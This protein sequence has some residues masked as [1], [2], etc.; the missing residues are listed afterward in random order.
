MDTG[1]LGQKSD[2]YLIKPLIKFDTVLKK[3]RVTLFCLFLTGFLPV[4]LEAMHIIGGEISYKYLGNGSGNNKRFQFTLR[5]FRD[6]N[7]GGAPF[8]NPAEIAIYRGSYNNNVFYTNFQVNL[9][10]KNLINPVIPDCALPGN[11][12]ECVEV[13]TY[14]FTRDLPLSATESYFIVYQRC[15]RNTSIYNLINPGDIGATYMVEV[16]P[17]AQSLGNSSPV[18]NEFPPVYICKDFPISFNHSATDADGDLLVYSLCAPFAGGG[19]DLAPPDNIGCNGATPTPPCAPPFLNVPFV[20]PDYSPTAP[21]GGNPVVTINTNTGMITGVPN[22]I[23]QFVVGVCV[24]EF[25]GATLMSTVKRDFQFNVIDCDPLVFAQIQ[26]DSVFGVKKYIVTSCGQRTVHL[27]NESTIKQYINSYE[28]SFDIQGTTLV[29]S[30]ENPTI[31]FPDTGVYYGVLILNKGEPCSDTAEIRVNIFPEI[32]ADYSY[33]YD[34]CVAGPVIFTDLSYSEAGMVDSWNWDFGVAGGGST[35]PSPEYLYPYP[36]NHI[37]QLTV[38]DKNQCADTKM[39]TIQWYPA[40]PY[41]IVQPDKFLG[42]TPAEITFTNLSSPID[43]TYFIVWDFGDGTRDT[44][45]ISPTHTYTTEGFYD[46]SVKI[47][48]PIGC[49]VQDSFINWI[50][51]STSPIANF[52]C[53]PD[54]GLTVFNKTVQFI[55]LSQHAYRWYWNFDGQETSNEQNP[56]YTFEDT[57]KVRVLLVVT[58]NSGCKDSLSKVLDILPEVRWFMPNAFSPNGDS[59]NDEFFGKGFLEGASDFQFTIWNRWGELVFEAN[60]PGARWNGRVKNTGSMSPVGLYVYVV[61]FTGP[62]G[63]KFEYRGYVALVR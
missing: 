12:N 50:K 31:T 11:A 36:G 32:K 55:D 41:I 26:N 28:W 59:V 56:I 60:D 58:H 63:K 22:T 43:S 18:F 25:R 53:D 52:T 4:C 49:F 10:S 44:G 6:C 33:T 2:F 57:G 19:P 54:S 7:G 21:M 9:Q 40:P 20:V 45:V 35:E 42:C 1:N 38:R 5:V 29:S 61:T 13:G 47:T 30:E 23:G 37:V 8:D 62:R 24:Q 3:L 48:S 46:V 17:T 15:C 27:V 39:D 51:V 34:T 14:V 16:S